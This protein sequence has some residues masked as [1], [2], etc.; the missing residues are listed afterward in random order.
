MLPRFVKFKEGAKLTYDELRLILISRL[1]W[2]CTHVWPSSFSGPPVAYVAGVWK[3]TG[4]GFRARGLAPK[5][6]SPCLSN[7]CHACY[8]IASLSDVLLA[9]HAI[10]PDSWRSPNEWPTI[11]LSMEVWPY[12]W[13]QKKY[14]LQT[15]FKGKHFLQENTWGKNSYTEKKNLSWCTILKKKILHL[16][17]SGKKILSP[18]VWETSYYPKQITHSPLPPNPQKSNGR[19]LRTFLSA[20]LAHNVFIVSLPA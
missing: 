12:G 10:L 7:A 8:V 9:R 1:L 14:I 3:G 11:W 13:F 2:L 6:P 19:P 17:M 16:C 5:F 4:R 20:R 18:E 15:D